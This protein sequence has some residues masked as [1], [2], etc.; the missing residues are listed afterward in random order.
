M[1]RWSAPGFVY[2]LCPAR[3]PG[4]FKEPNP[5]RDPVEAALPHG[6]VDSHAPQHTCVA[7]ERVHMGQRRDLGGQGGQRPVVAQG[8]EGNRGRAHQAPLA[9]TV[10]RSAGEPACCHQRHFCWGPGRA[11]NV[12]RD[13]ADVLG[14]FVVPGEE[15]ARHSLG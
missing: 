5:V 14:A 4:G 6:A 2:S 3:P 1:A 10:A 9:R 11:Q 12:G 7:G 15:A 13:A 8:G